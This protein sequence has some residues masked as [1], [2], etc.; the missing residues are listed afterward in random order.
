MRLQLVEDWKAAHKW[1]SVRLSA[2]FAAVALAYDYLPAVQSYI[3][4]YVSPH[5][6]AGLSG[7]IIVARIVTVARK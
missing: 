5:A 6:M 7:L 4:P 2:A 3:A 1:A